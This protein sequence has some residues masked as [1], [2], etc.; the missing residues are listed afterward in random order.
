MREA[1][2]AGRSGETPGRRWRRRLNP[3]WGSGSLFAH[4]GGARR[5]AAT[6]GFAVDPLRG[7]RMEF[8]GSA[9]GVSRTK[10][11][12]KLRPESGF[13]MKRRG[14]PGWRFGGLLVI[15][16]CEYPLHASAATVWVS[17]GRLSFGRLFWSAHGQIDPD[18]TDSSDHPVQ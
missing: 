9:S 7:N 16:V 10:A 5:D 3:G 8:G 6:P 14:S 15:L 12:R 2:A 4:T 17:F 1:G 13:R 11:S 18:I